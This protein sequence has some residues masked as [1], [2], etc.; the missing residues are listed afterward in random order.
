MSGYNLDAVLGHA[1]TLGLGGQL[2]LYPNGRAEPL[3]AIA[4][5]GQPATCTQRQ[6][7]RQTALLHGFRNVCLS[8]GGESPMK[9]PAPATSATHAEPA[10][11]VPAADTPPD[12]GELPQLAIPAKRRR[13]PSRR[14]CPLGGELDKWK[15]DSAGLA[16]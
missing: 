8:T 13:R 7:L 4:L 6:Q 12:S 16:G 11:T 2:T 5:A 1:H 14:N 10:S 15:D 3:P 9:T